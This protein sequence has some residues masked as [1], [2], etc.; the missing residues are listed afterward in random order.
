MFY[1]GDGNDIYK[2][3]YFTQASGAHFAIGALIDEEGDDE[4]ELFETAGAALAFGWDFTISFFLDKK[5]DDKYIA[6]IISLG[7]AQIRSNAFFFELGGSD[8]YKIKKKTEKLGAAT[9]RKGYKIPN[10]LSPYIYYANSFAL[11]IDIGGK[12]FYLIE[13][14]VEE[15]PYKNNAIWFQPAKSAPNFTV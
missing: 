8:I 11:F 5:G 4:H 14:E 3:C 7:V 9:F 1:D 6:K 12:D 10:P 13:D 2:S 15:I